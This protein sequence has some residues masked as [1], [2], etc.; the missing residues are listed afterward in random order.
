MMAPVVFLR[1]VR[2]ALAHLRLRSPAAGT[3]GTCPSAA[4]VG[5]ALSPSRPSAVR[6]RPTL[7][8]ASIAPTTVGAGIVPAG[9]EEDTVFRASTVL[10]LVAVLFFTGSQGEAATAQGTP[11][12]AEAIP[13]ILVPP[14]TSVLLFTLRAR[15]VQIYA[16]AA[17]PD[18]PTAFAWTFK[19]PEADL[20]NARGEVVGRHFAGPTWQ[21]NDGSAVVGAVLERADAPEPGAIPWLLLEAKEHEGNG[22]F[23]TVT[24]VQRLDTVGGVAPVEG[25]DAEHAGAEARVPYEAT[26]AFSYPAVAA[27]PGASGTP[28]Q[29]AGSVT[30]RVFSCPA[31]LSQPAGQGELDQAALLAACTPYASP[32][33]APTLRTLPDGQAMAGT[34]TAPGIYQWDGLAL[35]DY[36][37]GGSG[38]MPANLD[39]LL[40]TD[41]SGAPLQNPALRLDQ[42]TPHVE[43]R[44]FYFLAKS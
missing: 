29:Q 44:Y 6:T 10:V 27:T 15:G 40:V 21:G 3:R 38:E 25:C 22:A 34:M 28:A 33:V 19:A 32:E 14:P 41:A 4:A 39:S 20:L 26:Y 5:D 42:T 31:E 16:C 17:K 24:H 12:S 11:T 13:A 9:G 30:V 37:V 1:R 36:A 23:S 8:H 2:L 7:A 43:Y 18:D 35:G